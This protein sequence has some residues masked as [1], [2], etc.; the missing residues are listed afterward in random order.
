MKTRHLRQYWRLILIAIV[1]VL[2]AVCLWNTHLFSA[3]P[4]ASDYEFDG[5]SGAF[6]G[7]SG[8]TYV[9]DTARKE[10]LIL[11]QDLEYVRTIQ[12]GSTADGAFYYA[13]AVTDGPDGI[14]VA[15]ALYAG[16]GTIIQAERILRFEPDGSGGEVLYQ[17]DYP[18]PDTAPRQ[19]GRI[20]SLIRDGGELLFTAA[21]E[22]QVRVYAYDLASGA[23]TDHPGYTLKTYRVEVVG[24]DIM[25]DTAAESD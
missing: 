16:T 23:S 18:D 8:S 21:E 9:V 1:I 25:I 14:Y 24:D 2:G 13:T 19:Y 10:I 22:N 6:R 4:F 5:P 20:K 3:R 17:I 15:D 7:S 12:G 11:N